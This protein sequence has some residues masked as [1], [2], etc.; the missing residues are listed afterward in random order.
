MSEKKRGVRS[1]FNPD[2]LRKS[3]FAA[4]ETDYVGATLTKTGQ[5]RIMQ[6]AFHIGANCTDEDRLLKS[7]LKNAD[8]LL[9]QGISVPGPSRYRRLLRET[10]Q[11]LGADRPAPDTRDILIDAIVEDDSVSRI[12]LSNDNFIC[13]P[14]RIFDHGMVYPQAEHK[15][16]GL[17]RLFPDDEIA[18]FLSIRNPVTFLQETFQRAQAADL[19]TY[20]GFQQPSD[21]NWS[22]VI[23]RIKSGAPDSPLTVWCHEDSPLLWEDLIRAQ[24]G[25]ALDTQMLGGLDQIGD[26]LSPDG[27]AKLREAL[28]N[29]AT[30]ETLTR[31]EIIANIWEQHGLDDAVDYEIE[32]PGFTPSVITALTEQY[33]RDLEKIDAMEGV[34]L[35]LPFR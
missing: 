11:N 10:I 21:L 19:E 27:Q 2:G 8:T 12:V 30:T 23:A 35:L 5:A 22:D 18:L 33:E 3:G 16:R 6:I 26:L 14:K 31:Q 28:N 17:H 13:I 25:V 29:T 4:V 24:S 1:T 15:V 9:Q 20:L 32:L 34:E 7:I